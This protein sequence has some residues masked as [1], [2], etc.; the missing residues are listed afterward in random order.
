MGRFVLDEAAMIP[1]PVFE[2]ELL[3]TA[4]R[5][6]YFALRAGYA[7]VILLALWQLHRGWEDM[8]GQTLTPRQM[9]N[10]ARSAFI[11]LAVMQELLVLALTPALVAGVI[12]AEKQSKTLHYLMACPLSGLEIVFG[13]LLARLLHMGTFLAV[14]LPILS[15][16]VLLGGV[17]PRLILLGCGVAAASA[18]MLAGLSIVVSTYARRVREALFLVYALELLWLLLPELLE[19]SNV[20]N[21]PVV[22]PWFDVATNWALA[23]SP[24]A[25]GWQ[26]LMSML[27][28]TFTLVD[29]L[30]WMAGLQA[31]AG[32]LMVLL[33]AWRLRR[34]VRAQADSTRRTIIERLR[35]RGSWRLLARPECG[36]RPME[37]KER[38]TSRST[39]FTRIVGALL[40]LAVGLPLVYWTIELAAPAIAEMGA[41]AGTWSRFDY[42]MTKSRLLFHTFISTTVP[43]LFLLGIIGVAGAAAA[44]ITSEHEDDT[45]LSLTATDLTGRE[46]VFAKLRGALF[47]PRSLAAAG[48]ALVLLGGLSGSLHPVGVLPIGV[49]TIVYSWFAAALGLWISLQ[50]RSTWRA[51]FLTLSFLFLINLL[52][53]G[54]YGV[55]WP[56]QF[57][58][59]PGLMPVELARNAYRPDEWHSVAATLANGSFSSDLSPVGSPF[60]SLS[61]VFLGACSVLTYATLAGLLTWAALRRF[62]IAAGRPRRAFRR[63]PKSLRASVDDETLSP[64]PLAAW[65]PPAT[66]S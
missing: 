50:L 41:Q 27:L 12:A 63:H 8:Y 20:F 61:G 16:L 22:G 39:R 6:R 58:I 13:K 52:G 55:L 26:F 4:R 23:S 1:G 66:G 11:A 28:G 56:F 38:Y 64:V 45:W 62:E 33:A 14:G 53:Q 49:S 34:V 40:V 18:F 44:S 42:S 48:G 7:V 46:I 60:R 21:W 47:G 31:V 32:V 35:A 17:D 65:A 37:W 36:N 25:V 57:P 5:G 30:T 59:W 29:D 51:Q 54:A 3:T 19:R 2:F 15:L 24:V 10:Y 43:L 9:S